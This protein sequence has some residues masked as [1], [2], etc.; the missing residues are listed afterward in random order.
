MISENTYSVFWNRRLFHWLY[1]I[2][3]PCESLTFGIVSYAAA[4]HD[5]FHGSFVKSVL[6]SDTT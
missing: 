1:L 5:F 3:A 2:E 6:V 4:L